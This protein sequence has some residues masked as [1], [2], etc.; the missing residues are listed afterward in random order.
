MQSGSI[1]QAVYNTI[2]DTSIIYPRILWLKAPISQVLIA[3]RGVLFHFCL[4]DNDAYRTF[5]FCSTEREDHF[6][7]LENVFKRS[8]KEPSCQGRRRHP[9]GPARPELPPG[10]AR[11]A[12]AGPLQPRRARPPAGAGSF[13]THIFLRNLASIQPRTSPLKFAD[14]PGDRWTGDADTLP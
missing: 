2:I 6:Q 12:P 5:F 13:Q 10:A 8:S 9:S 11:R 3:T 7:S 14:D 4:V 1:L